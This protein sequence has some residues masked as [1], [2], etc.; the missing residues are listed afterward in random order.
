MLRRVAIVGSGISG[1][2]AAYALKRN[3][4]EVDL[5]ERS[6]SITEFGAGITLSKNATTLLKELKLMEAL[7]SK[8]N[9]PM[10][11]YIRNYKSANIINS[12]DFDKNFI[13]MDR[14]D[15]VQTLAT[16]FEDIGGT[17]HFGKQIKSVDPST[18]EVSVSEEETISY[19]LILFCDGINSLLR[20]LYIDEQ[21]PRF[22]NY[23]AWRGIISEDNLPHYEGSDKV[24]VYYGPGGHCVHYPIGGEGLINF[25]AIEHNSMWSEES[26]KIEGNKSEFL[27]RFKDWNETLVHM[28]GSA[29][30]IYKWG[31][32]QRPPPKKLYKDKCVLLGDAAHPMVPFLGQGGCL[33]IEDAFCLAFLLDNNNDL[34]TA[35]EKYDKVRNR[36][37]KL[38][39]RR[40]QFQGLF[41]HISNP[42]A[43]AA[44]NFLVKVMMNSS[45]DK[46]HSYNLIN[47]LSKVES[48]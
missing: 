4:I 45:V 43:V 16:K 35:L 46:I 13:T 30:K 26:W 39:Q 41:N 12:M 24:N 8:S 11:S 44:R 37:A 36:R 23:V 34:S 19:D 40:S 15:L 48:K 47:E 25:I 27:E 1:L 18:G 33:A 31:I 3:N 10:R 20:N 38:M 17:I 9:L 2:T 42:L 6:Q 29:E 28:L 5:F 21:E 7:S 22:T 14:R 32:F